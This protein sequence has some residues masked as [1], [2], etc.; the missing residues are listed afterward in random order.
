MSCP[1]AAGIFQWHHHFPYGTVMGSGGQKFSPQMPAWL[2]LLTGRKKFQNYFLMNFFPRSLVSC[3][4]TLD[5]FYF[6]P[7][8]PHTLSP[9]TL[10][11]QQGPF[12]VTV[13]LLRRAVILQTCSAE[14]PAGGDFEP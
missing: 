2:V 12:K 6:C 14:G 13:F 7:P 11:S 4:S 9:G 10:E 5:H 8:P 1:V 3:V